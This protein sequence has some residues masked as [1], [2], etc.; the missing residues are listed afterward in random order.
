MTHEHEH[1]HED[2][3]THTHDHEKGEHHGR[4]IEHEH[5]HSHEDGT[6]HTHD[7]E[8]GEHHGGRE[9]EDWDTSHPYFIHFY[10]RPSRQSIIE[11]LL[12]NIGNYII[13]N[14]IDIISSFLLIQIIYAC[15]LIALFIEDISRKQSSKHC[16]IQASIYLWL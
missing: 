8:K 15:S 9:I 5:E 13:D 3:T 12:K 6:T 2:G 10:F 14:N 4:E 1:S 16:D 11:L 7:H